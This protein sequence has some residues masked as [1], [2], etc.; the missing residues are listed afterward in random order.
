MRVIR[1]ALLCVAAWPSACLDMPITR[2][3]KTKGPI[4]DTDAA[5]DGPA[6]PQAA[7]MVCMA[8]PEEPGPGCQTIYRTCRED[9]KCS[10]FI[11]CGFER[12]CFQGSKKALFNCGLPCAN[13]GGVLTPD[14]PAL[15]L[16]ANLFQCLANGPC[17]DICFSS[18]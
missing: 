14:D 8:A 11:D 6:G 4:V 15:T 9:A 10:V 5:T 16:A 18:D 3:D 1:L 17:G 2:I 13:I 7:C 12:E